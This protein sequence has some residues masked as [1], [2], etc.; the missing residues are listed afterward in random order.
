MSLICTNCILTN[1]NQLKFIYAGFEE[2]TCHCGSAVLYPPIPC[3]TLPPECNNP[4]SRRHTCPHPGEIVWLPSLISSLQSC[5]FLCTS[6][7]WLTT[8]KWC[9]TLHRSDICLTVV[10]FQ[11][12]TDRPHLVVVY[13]SCACCQISVFK[14]RPFPRHLVPL[15][16][17]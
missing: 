8:L 10:V 1:H 11:P 2:L 13:S 4:C 9:L 15:F 12:A 16:Q 17:N 14:N 6:S 7:S 5:V 3:G